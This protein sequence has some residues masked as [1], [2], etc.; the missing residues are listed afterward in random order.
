MKIETIVRIVAIAF[1]ILVFLP[2]RF[3]AAGA[4]SNHIRKLQTERH[5]MMSKSK[6]MPL[7]YQFFSFLA[8]S[9]THTSSLSFLTKQHLLANAG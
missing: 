5:V 3:Q 7:S 8:E 1:G 4:E 9:E 2:T 6:G